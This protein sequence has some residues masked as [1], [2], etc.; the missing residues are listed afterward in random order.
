MHI[1]KTGIYNKLI[2]LN[3]ASL[4]TGFAMGMA[5]IAGT[6]VANHFIKKIEK[7]KFQNYIAVM[8]CIVGAYMLVFGG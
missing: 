8:L 5:M 1:L 6:F 3:V 7:G 2:G 4:V